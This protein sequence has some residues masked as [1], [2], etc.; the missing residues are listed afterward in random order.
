MAPPQKL[1]VIGHSLGITLLKQ[2]LSHSTT[3][4]LENSYIA[5]YHDQTTKQYFDNPDSWLISDL[6]VI[7]SEINWLEH[8][9]NQLTLQISPKDHD[10]NH[11]TSVSS[12]IIKAESNKLSTKNIS[13]SI[14]AAEGTV[15]YLNNERIC[16]RFK[17][18]NRFN[19]KSPVKTSIFEENED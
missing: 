2:N 18:I 17:T 8:E 19:R 11:E 5:K 14:N 6:L 1:P 9:A 15:A 13:Y 7:I 10:S 16:E 4:E 3:K 12:P